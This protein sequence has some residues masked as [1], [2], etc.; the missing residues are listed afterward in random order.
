MICRYHTLAVRKVNPTTQS[1]S[2]NSRFAISIE[3]MELNNHQ[4]ECIKRLFRKRRYQACASHALSDFN[5][6]VPQT[7]NRVHPQVQEFN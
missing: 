7:S 6:T 1:I 4:H 2:I 5:P 3:T